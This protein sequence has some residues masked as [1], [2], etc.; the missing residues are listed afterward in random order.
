MR[1][2]SIDL[3]AWIRFAR[4]R[5]LAGWA[6][7]FLESLDPLAP[8]GAQLLYLIEPLTGGR[9]GTRQVARSLEDGEAR[10]ALRQQLAE[11][12]PD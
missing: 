8:L 7:F 5:R 1:P 4:R 6:A 11:E 9:S 10:R 3:D 2:P 12:T